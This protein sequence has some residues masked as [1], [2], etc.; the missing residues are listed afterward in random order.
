MQKYS[1]N[2][3]ERCIEHH[4]KCLSKFINEIV[5]SNRIVDLMKNN[6]GNYVVQKALRISNGFEKVQLIDT[7][8]KN[9]SRLGDKKLI[10][11]WRSIVNPHLENSNGN[12][13]L[14]VF[15]GMMI[16][17]S[18]NENNVLGC[19]IIYNLNDDNIFNNDNLIEISDRFESSFAV[20]GLMK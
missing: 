14:N 7:V 11:K 5:T 6:F 13:N 18:L 8:A 17:N 2:V 20:S 3:I 15:N 12:F 9:I 1:S 4:P 10:S 19:K 16:Q